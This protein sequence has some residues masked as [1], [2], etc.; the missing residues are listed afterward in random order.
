M[1]REFRVILAG[2]LVNRAGTFVVPFLTLYLTT[3]R[4][5]TPSGAGLVLVGFGLGAMGSQI[6][7]GYLTDHLGRRWTLAGGMFA[8]SASL[9]ALGAARNTA[10][11][12]AAALL[13][14]LSGD[15]FRPASQALVAD[16]VPPD[17]RPYAFAL[18]FWAVNLGFAIAGV[19]AGFLAE[20]GYWLLF[21][22]DSISCAAFAVVVLVG[23]RRDPPRVVHDAADGSPAPGYRTALR[24][25]TFVILVLC[26]CAQAVAY[27]Q[28]FL[29][30]PLA[31]TDAGLPP[32]AYGLVA[33]ANGLVIV[34]LQPFAARITSRYDPSRTI[35][36]SL[37]ITGI[38]FW[39]TTFATTL[40]AF[41]ACTL[42]WTLGEIGVAGHLP[43]IVSDLADPAARG[44]Y[45]G[46]FGLAFG[47]AGFIA[48]LAGPRLY[49]ARGAAWLWSACLVLFVVS[50]LGNLAIRRTVVER[51]VRYA[52]ASPA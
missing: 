49:E 20:R 12:A 35:A 18:I 48:P 19:T 1:P 16:V 24:D 42:V 3:Q 46:L 22:V 30:L 13:V 14:G 50:A 27:F 4:G 44:R 52:A 36:V 29:V 51:R 33:G 5:F 32:S 26:T 21:A 23:I 37:T 11:I 10:T 47:I 9:L 39:L 8:A 45:M 43:A 17:R 6:L 15:I 34:A 7:G 40:P 28:S 31:V 2:T 25:T 41:L 38:G